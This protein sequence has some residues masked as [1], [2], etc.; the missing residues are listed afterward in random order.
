MSLRMILFKLQPFVWFHHDL[1]HAS[2]QETASRWAADRWLLQQ[3]P[4]D[5]SWVCPRDLLGRYN[6]L[7]ESLSK[8]ANACQQTLRRMIN[9]NTILKL[10][11][12]C[13]FVSGLFLYFSSHIESLIIYVDRSLL[14]ICVYSVL[15]PTCVALCREIFSL[16]NTFVTINMWRVARSHSYQTD[17]CGNNV[18]PP[19]LVSAG[20]LW[21]SVR[22]CPWVCQKTSV[23]HVCVL[24]VFR[25]T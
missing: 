23:W 1:S 22:V 17:F 7:S 11:R 3:G 2:R 18:T 6:T 14:H 12:K 15:K 8:E 4:T 9:T 20:A 13:L 25:D 10:E 24:S 19:S 16:S 5:C 21:L